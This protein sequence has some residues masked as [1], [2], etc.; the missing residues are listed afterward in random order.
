[1]SLIAGITGVLC[2]LIAFVLD[3]FYQK[4][5]PETVAYNALNIAGSGLLIYY[6]YTLQ[7]WPFVALNGVWLI[8]AAIKLTK[9][10]KSKKS[11]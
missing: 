6:A 1:M 9:I 10:S 4:I 2:I 5:N 11:P 7:S 3:E 8:A